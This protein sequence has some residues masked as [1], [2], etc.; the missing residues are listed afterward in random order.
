[1]AKVVNINHVGIVVQDNA[2]SLK[3]WR[4]LLGVNLKC[5]EP[6]PSMNINL[7]W[8]PINTGFIELLEPTTTKDNEYFEFLQS[9]GPGFHHV[10]LEVD[11]ID[12]MVEKLKEN[13][14]RFRS[15]SI[16]YLP[17]RK[18]IFLDPGCC[19]GVI[20]ELYELL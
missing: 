14:V 19:D 3:F 17:G 18:L 9:S 20:V 13:N 15:D 8:L 5:V 16:I 11:D 10:C 6:V 7:A 1:V 2:K 12:G 4:D